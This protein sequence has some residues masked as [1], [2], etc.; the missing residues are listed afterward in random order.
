MYLCSQRPASNTHTYTHASTEN[1]TDDTDAKSE[2]SICRAVCA[3]AE[4]NKQRRGHLQPPPALRMPFDA[5]RAECALVCVA[6]GERRD[7]DAE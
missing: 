5:W 1:A 6:P 2:M 3:Q 7:V 4:G